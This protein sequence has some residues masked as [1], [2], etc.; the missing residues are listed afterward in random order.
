M[1][2]VHE[3]HTGYGRAEVLH[4]VNM[5]VSSGRVTAIIGPNGA[6]KTTLM[7]AIA[8]TRPIWKG[9]I[10]IDNEDVTR[11]PAPDRVRRGIVL[12]PEGRRIFS[13]L[14]VEENIRIGATVLHSRSKGGEATVKQ[15]LERAYDLFPILSERRHK[16]GGTLSGGQQQMLAIARSLASSP[17]YLLL[18]EPS[19]GL[20]PAVIEHVY[21]ILETLR[22]EG[23]GMVLV[24]EG[25]D[26]ALE[27]ADFAMV[28]NGG[29][30]V[31]EGTA[32][33]LR[34]RHDLATSYLGEM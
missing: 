8:G 28:L 26:R 22:S 1:I 19:L 9:G 6:G 5:S 30:V 3:V 16:A 29:R 11:L 18:D 17:E 32:S 10:D 12:C 33:E 21:A 7:A 23:L 31:L 25:A 13:S 14:S 34:Q 24:E 15:A 20:A 27:F 2:R 4:G